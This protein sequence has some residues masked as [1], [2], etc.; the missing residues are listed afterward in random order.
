MRRSLGTLPPVF[1]IRLASSAKERQLSPDFFEIP[2]T[3][4]LSGIS[5]FA[6]LVEHIKTNE[7]SSGRERA[8]F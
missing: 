3:A 1:F 8:V 4:I 2:E 6:L 5:A 7:C